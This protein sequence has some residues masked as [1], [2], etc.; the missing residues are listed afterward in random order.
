MPQCVDQPTARELEIAELSINGYSCEEIAI[1]L[2]I[3]PT[4]VRMHLRNLYS[5]MDVS[6]I[7]AL[8]IRLYKLERR[9]E[10]AWKSRG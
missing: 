8:T 2:C 1:Q 6:N 9:S 10:F 3:S 4:T 5:K 7:R